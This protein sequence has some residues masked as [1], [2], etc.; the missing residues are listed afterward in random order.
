MVRTTPRQGPGLALWRPR[1]FPGWRKASNSFRDSCAHVLNFVSTQSGA[2][3]KITPAV[4]ML[5]TP[6][7]PTEVAKG[8]AIQKSGTGL[9]PFRPVRPPVVITN[10]FASRVETCSAGHAV[11]ARSTTIEI[12]IV[13][14]ASQVQV[15]AAPCLPEWPRR[16]TKCCCLT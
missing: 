13:V 9:L 14:R 4:I 3:V 12:V 7:L 5:A 15:K 2:A 11:A 8:S 6:R 16:A 10:T 1:G